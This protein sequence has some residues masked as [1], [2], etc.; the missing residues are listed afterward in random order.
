MFTA[1]KCCEALVE[2]LRP[3]QIGEVPA[4]DTGDESPAAHRA[5]DTGPPFMLPEELHGM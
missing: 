5:F 4:G 2:V 3:Q 1:W